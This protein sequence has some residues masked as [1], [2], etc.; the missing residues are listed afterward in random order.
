VQIVTKKEEGFAD[1]ETVQDI[2]MFGGPN[3]ENMYNRVDEWL[4]TPGGKQVMEMRKKKVSWWSPPQRLTGR[5]LK[6]RLTAR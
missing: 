4:V 3:N 2:I 5:N 6:K 1:Y